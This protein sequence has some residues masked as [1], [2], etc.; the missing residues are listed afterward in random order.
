MTPFNIRWGWMPPLD[1]AGAIAAGV[2][3]GTA[4]GIESGATAGATPS[5]VVFGTGETDEAGGCD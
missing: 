5:G 4:A 3:V 1:G 2:G